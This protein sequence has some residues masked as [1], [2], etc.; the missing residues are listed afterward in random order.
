[1]SNK[2]ERATSLGG[3]RR[4][5]GG[6]PNNLVFSRSGREAA[7]FRREGLW[8]VVVPFY[9]VTVLLDELSQFHRFARLNGSG[10]ISSSGAV[11]PRT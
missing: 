9:S 11:C 10:N 6:A 8:L 7:V 5:K 4:V 1:M 3:V 2:Y